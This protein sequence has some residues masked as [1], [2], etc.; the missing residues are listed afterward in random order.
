MPQDIVLDEIKLPTGEEKDATRFRQIQQERLNRN[1]RRL[2]EITVEA[3]LGT[4]YKQIIESIQD[5][6]SD[7]QG[8]ITTLSNTVSTLSGSLTTLSTT[9]SNLPTI[10]HGTG[11]PSGGKSGDVYIKHS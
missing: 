8:T 3:G 5:D 4:E 2:L 7:M 1:F 6:V 9:V 11:T 10:T